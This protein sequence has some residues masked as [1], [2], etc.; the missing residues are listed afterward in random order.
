MTT[1]TLEGYT[2]PR[3]HRWQYAYDVVEPV[4]GSAASTP[5]VVLHT[6][7]GLG[8]NRQFWNPFFRAITDTKSC[9]G[10][11]KDSPIYRFDWVGNG[12]SDPKPDSVDEAY[13]SSYFA[14][15]IQHFIENC[16]QRDAAGNRDVNIKPILV[17]QGSAVP[18][19]LQY[20][21]E[22][23]GDSVGGFVIGRRN[24]TSAY[25]LLCEV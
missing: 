14:A 8:V 13:D 19:T 23:G 24:S 11:L 1:A 16:V 3:S 5:I 2:D 22:Y 17:V 15:Q 6:P 21:T 7:A 4:E 12:D 25:Y 18:I 10:Q 20:F 9:G